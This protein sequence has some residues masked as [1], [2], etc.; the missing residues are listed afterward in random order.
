MHRVI[1]ERSEV[2]L[3]LKGRSLAGKADKVK[4]GSRMISLHQTAQHDDS[5]LPI[6]SAFYLAVPICSSVDRWIFALH[7]EPILQSVLGILV[8]ESK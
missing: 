3:H 6:L 1:E 2:G 7:T 8:S 4:H 5:C